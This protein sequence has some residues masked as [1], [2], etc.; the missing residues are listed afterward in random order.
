MTDP[1]SLPAE[2][3]RW[4]RLILLL[5]W[6]LILQFGWAIALTFDSLPVAGIVIWLVQA[7]PLLLFAPGLYGSRL[8]AYFWLSFLLLPYFMHAVLVAFSPSRLW[9]GLVEA[10]LCTILFCCLLGFIRQYRGYFQV[11]L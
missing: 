10:A 5:Y 3:L 2:L 9:P 4:R 7:L 1:K 8:R 11:N 6:C